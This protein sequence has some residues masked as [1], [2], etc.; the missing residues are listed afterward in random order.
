MKKLLAFVLCAGSFA[1][2]QLSQGP[3][4]PTVTAGGWTNPNNI[5]VRDFQYASKVVLANSN[6]AN[7]VTS[8]FGFSVPPSATV[9]GILLTVYRSDITG[10]GDLSDHTI[11]LRNSSGAIGNNKAD[12]IDDWPPGPS[13]ATYG[14]ASDVWGISSPTGATVDDTAFGTLIAVH[15]S[16]SD[17]SETPG[18][19]FVSITVYYRPVGHSFGSVVGQTRTAHLAHFAS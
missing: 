14:G 15:N 8:G 17:S 4:G 16:N 11:Q 12:L 2:A 9:V 10:F 13:I 5:F 6:S 1:A 19:D 7:N 18:L 3:F